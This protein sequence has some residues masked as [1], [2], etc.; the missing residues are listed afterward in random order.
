MNG[1][2]HVV[3]DSGVPL[4]MQGFPRQ[5]LAGLG[6]DFSD[7]E[8]LF[9]DTGI[10]L[11]PSVPIEPSM[12]DPTGPL[13]APASLPTNTQD[14]ANLYS[15][16]VATGAITPGQAAS[17]ATAAINAANSAAKAAGVALAPS[18]RVATKAVPATASILPASLTQATII[19]GIPN[20]A[21]IGGGLLLAFA[22]M[23]G[24]R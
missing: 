5:H 17:M 13:V 7:P 4:Y 22:A 20:F 14:I 15:S 8:N 6:D 1:H 10:D 11:S 21:I 12:Y 2:P 3:R 23:G 18:P 9:L 16:A 24:K 19:P